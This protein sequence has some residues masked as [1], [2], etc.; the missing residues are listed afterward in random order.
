MNVYDFDNTIYNG[1][2]TLDFFLFC[3][4]KHPKIIKY[5]PRQI[6]GFILYK[7]HKIT[8][9]EFKEMFFSFLSCLVDAKSDVASFWKKN[10]QKIKPWYIS[11][12]S[13]T[14]IVISASPR[15]LL[16]MICQELN[17]ND[18]IASEVDI[19]SGKFSG[20]NCHDEVKVIL[21]RKKYPDSIIDNFYSDSIS[22]LPMAKI[23]TNAYLVKKS[24]I[25]KWS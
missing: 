24:V 25:T 17:I 15:F 14:D 18:L 12:R 7:S 8:K 10:E 21:F 6:Y 22:D 13:N 11:Q 1:D 2:S 19:T 9:K 23:A 3:L 4:K 16:E 20:E 5:I